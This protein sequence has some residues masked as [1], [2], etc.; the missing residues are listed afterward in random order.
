MT[1]GMTLVV[2]TGK[3]KVGPVVGFVEAEETEAR[4][5]YQSS[6]CLNCLCPDLTILQRVTIFDE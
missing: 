4:L 1:E 5:S 6:L 3:T 2:Q